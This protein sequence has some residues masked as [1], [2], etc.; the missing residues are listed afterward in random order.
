MEYRDKSSHP[1]YVILT[2]AR[3]ERCYI[4]QVLASVVSQTLKPLRWVIADDGSTD[5]TD[6]VVN[7]YS[8]IHRFI[9]IAQ[10]TPNSQRGFHSKA[11]ALKAGERL[12]SG[13]KY[14]YIAN[15]DA[16]VSFSADYF[17]RVLNYFELDPALGIG[18]G[19]LM[20]PKGGRWV[21]PRSNKD[22][23]VRGGIQVFRRECFI[24]IGGYIPLPFGGIDTVA[25]VTAR[26]KGWSVRA[27]SEV[28]AL[29]HRR[30]G[31]SVSRLRAAYR[32]GVQEYLNGS[33]PLFEVLKCLAHVVERP[34]LLSSWARMGGYIW[35]LVRRKEK[36]VPD[37]IVRY[38]R[39]E[40]ILRI[41]RTL[42]DP[43]EQWPARRKKRLAVAD[44]SD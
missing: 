10:V 6:V 41:A 1:V 24:E 16:D 4:D 18:G 29:H 21:M 3:N 30:T 39:R 34:W 2:A 38:Q 5:G 37:D 40:Q 33:H 22:W 9:C 32:L 36:A 31:G 19:V 15:V 27:C 35:Y 17:E 14:D 7:R 26:M 20:E 25:E 28:I 43:N 8:E 11:L 13:L 12:L 23:S 44:M 42:C